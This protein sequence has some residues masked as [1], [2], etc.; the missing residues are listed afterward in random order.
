MTHFDFNHLPGAILLPPDRFEA[1]LDSVVNAHW[2]GADRATIPF[3]VYCYGP[4]C[5]R[6]RIATT[7]AAHRGFRNLLWYR[8]GPQA[9]RSAGGQLFGK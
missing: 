8:D 5:I 4:D 9:Y 1:Q 7:T 2:P 6:S 3:A